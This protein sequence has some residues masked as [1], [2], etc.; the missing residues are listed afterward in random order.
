MLG[1]KQTKK[2]E[3]STK[4]LSGV[5]SP[6][7]TQQCFLQPRLEDPFYQKHTQ[8]YQYHFP[9]A[10]IGNTT[11]A[12][13]GLLDDVCCCDFIVCGKSNEQFVAKRIG[14]MTATFARQA[15]AVSSWCRHAF[16]SRSLS[17]TNCMP[18][19]LDGTKYAFSFSAIA[20][21]FVAWWFCYCF[22]KYQD[23]HTSNEALAV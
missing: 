13:C 21:S 12:T 22:K 16:V 6:Y 18:S 10:G 20:I 15:Y 17:M 7:P 23:A 3:Y 2:S 1:T 14:E 4:P 9:H 5:S 11:K 8:F 19:R